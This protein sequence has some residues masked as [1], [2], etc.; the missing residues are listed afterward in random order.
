MRNFYYHE[1]FNDK[2]NRGKDIFNCVSQT[3]LVPTLYSSMRRK[4]FGV[5]AGLPT[6]VKVFA[7]SLVIVEGKDG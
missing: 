3:C 6:K 4:R 2:S 5:G 1:V 7:A